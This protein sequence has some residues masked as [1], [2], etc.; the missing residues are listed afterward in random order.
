MDG[1]SSWYFNVVIGAPVFICGFSFCTVRLFH[2]CRYCSQYKALGLARQGTTTVERRTS[3]KI[4]L[5]EIDKQ[6]TDHHS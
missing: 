4:Q 5:G 1:E 3:L 2:R 6:Y